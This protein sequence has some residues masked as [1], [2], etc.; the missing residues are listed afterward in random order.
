MSQVPDAGTRVRRGWEIRVAQSLGPQRIGV[1][2]VTGESERVAELNIRRRGLEIGSLAEANLPD[3]ASSGKVVA[4][5]PPANASGVSTPKI[6]MLVSDGP[7]PL[8]FVMPNLVGQPLGS[9]TLSLQDA[10]LKVGKVTV[11]PPPAA[12]PATPDQATQ[13]SENPPPP[14]QANA[15]SMIMTQWPSAGQ[16]VVAGSFVNFE[17]R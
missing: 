15:A 14:V 12:P 6:S 7:P 4:Q 5:S 9:A 10:G 11:V 17:V 2:D 16:K 13:P 8:E 1:P 3:P